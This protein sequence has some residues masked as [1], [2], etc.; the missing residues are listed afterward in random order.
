LDRFGT[1]HIHDTFVESTAEGRVLVQRINTSVFGDVDA[2]M[3]NLRTVI[4]HVRMPY[5]V[6]R[7]W[8]DDDGAPWRA[9]TLVEGTRQP[10]PVVARADAPAVGRAIG[11]FHIAVADLD[12]DRLRVVL[13]AFHDPAARW[14]ELETRAARRV[15]VDDELARLA[16]LRHLADVAD[17]WRPP[18]VPVRA[19]H[20]D[21]KADNVLLDVETGEPVALID[22]DTVMPGSWLWDVGDMVRSV[23]ATAA[24]DD[25]VGMAMDAA[26]WRAVM[27][28][29]VRVAGDLLT[30]AERA[31]LPDAGPVVTWE[32]AV[33]FLA[34]HVAGDR[35]Y[36]VTR[37][38]HNLDRARAQ[39]A[40]VE[41]MVAQRS[42]MMRIP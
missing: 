2:L 26:K 18:D 32:Q 29:Y 20:H 10:D 34:D 21:A 14:R 23:T 24:E 9:I 17:G 30:R 42:A 6:V 33:R 39:L 27:N 25:P 41:S 31:A 3:A 12:P 38:G 37:A 22:L 28:G 35:Y 4:E 13:P 19:A 11:A 36:K 1:G 5:S 40:L 7:Q 15:D 8:V 16:A